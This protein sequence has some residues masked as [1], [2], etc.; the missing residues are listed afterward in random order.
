MREKRL[1][2]GVIVEIEIRSL[3]LLVH[4]DPKNE[5]VGHAYIEFEERVEEN[6]LEGLLT[7]AREEERELEESFSSESNQQQGEDVLYRHFLI[8]QIHIA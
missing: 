6:G 8:A 3:V 2:E 7:N 4:H 1:T 5:D